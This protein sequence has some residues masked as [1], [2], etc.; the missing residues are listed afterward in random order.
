MIGRLRALLTSPSA[1]WR[2]IAQAPPG[3]ARVLIGWLLPWALLPFAA[4]LLRF[5]LFA[6]IFG[7]QASVAVASTL[8]GDAA[9]RYAF[10]VGWTLAVAWVTDALAP[11]FE[12]RR[13]YGRA[14][15]VVTG[16]LAP[17]FVLS[18][19]TM[20]PLVGLLVWAGVPWAIWLLR[21]GLPPV[22]GCPEARASAY[23]LTVTAAAILLAL[24][25]LLIPSCAAPAAP[26]AGE[27]MAAV[28]APLPEGAPLPT[29]QGR[30][31][32]SPD[33]RLE[34]ADDKGLGALN[35]DD[36]GGKSIDELIKEMVDPEKL[37]ELER[38]KREVPRVE[39]NIP[40]KPAE[41]SAL[42]EL[43]P[44]EVCGLARTEIEST[45][46]RLPG[47][48]EVAI[49][50]ATFGRRGQGSVRMEIGD[51][52]PTALGLS[53]IR[54]L[55]P[56]RDVT[57]A[58]GYQRMRTEGDVFIDDRWDQPRRESQFVIVLA[59][60]FAVSAVAEGQSAPGCAES[61]VR[62]VDWN[63]L[64]AMIGAPAR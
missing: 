45:L 46:S 47:G 56:T 57:T 54:R 14:L 3:A 22:M 5:W 8:L 49:A 48:G 51:R 31:A 30:G 44:L 12:G 11:R 16:A 63:A 2:D 38:L 28:V 43:M 42:G 23:A 13:G 9:G 33:E 29:T 21:R 1:A 55:F 27:P 40:F 17:L 34:G 19:L 60:R 36:L 6:S 26:G 64:R 41:P 62:R 59:D 20:L 52:S 58:R 53:Q 25:A 10:L 37:K 7:A 61:A 18:L 15:T 24:L 39:A 50:K 32:T 35:L 4:Y